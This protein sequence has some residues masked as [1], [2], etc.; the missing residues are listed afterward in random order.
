MVESSHTKAV[1]GV[2]LATA[3]AART[4]GS[5]VT[6]IDWIAVYFSEVVLKMTISLC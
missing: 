4:A 5:V 6:H 1:D 2:D 3:A